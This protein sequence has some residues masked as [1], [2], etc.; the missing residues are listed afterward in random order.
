MFWIFRSTLFIISS[1]S[2]SMNKNFPKKFTTGYPNFD[3]YRIIRLAAIFI[4]SSFSARA[5]FSSAIIVRSFGGHLLPDVSFYYS[6]KREFQFV[7]FIWHH[8]NHHHHH[9]KL[10]GNY[11]LYGSSTSSH[12]SPIDNTGTEVTTT[13]ILLTLFRCYRYT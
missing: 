6:S 1:N 7:R 11:S 3:H 13:L 5:T 12:W 4:C 9:G 8:R 2:L 10:M